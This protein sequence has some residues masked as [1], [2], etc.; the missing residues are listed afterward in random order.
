MKITN[1]INKSI[2]REYDIR[3]IYGVDLN[4]DV[5]YTLGRSFATY[6]KKYNSNKVIVGHDNRHSSPILHDALVKGI[7]DSGCD[8]ID[9]GLVTT[10]MYY[11]GRIKY[12]TPTGIMITASHNPKEY[13]GFKISLITI[14][15]VP[16]PQ[17]S[18]TLILLSISTELVN[19]LM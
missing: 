13:N 17:S 6:I 7:N 11:Y 5:A 10:P 14:D 12:D 4:E 16:F 3:G 1:E 19:K 9:L 15:P 8:V 18:T 2:F